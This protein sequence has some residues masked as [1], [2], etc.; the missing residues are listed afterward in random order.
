MTRHR[1]PPTQPPAHPAAVLRA[2]AAILLAL[3]FIGDRAGGRAAHAQ[4]SFTRSD[5]IEVL[6]VIPPP[7]DATNGDVWADGRLVVV[8]QRSG[9][10][11]LFDASVPHRT[12][13]VAAVRGETFTQD[14]KIR[15]DLVAVTNETAGVGAGAV[16]FGVTNP[17][18]PRELS[19]ITSP[20]ARSVH[21]L[22]I[23]DGFLYLS[24]NNTGRVEIFDI[25]I[26]AAPLHVASVADPNGRIHDAVV[27]GGRLYSSFLGGGFTVH[28]VSDPSRPA[29]LVS[30]DYPEAFTH[31]AWPSPDGRFLYTTDEVQGGH[32][33]VWDLG[34]AGGGSG[35]VHQVGRFIASEPAIIHNVHASGD[36]VFAAYYTA[37]LRILD[38]STPRLPV[39]VAFLDTFPGG[40][41][42]FDGAWGVHPFNEL[43]IAYISDMATGLWVVRFD[44]RVAAAPEDLQ[45]RAD[46]ERTALFAR[47]VVELRW[48]RHRDSVGYNIYRAETGAP[49]SRLNRTPH[50]DTTFLDVLPPDRQDAEYAVSA[51]LPDGTES[52]PSPIVAIRT[53]P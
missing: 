2:L 4:P 16:L 49:F 5:N 24:S 32:M 22:W 11:A 48:R 25:R 1:C 28:D 37:G 19:R 50:P 18:A 33:R 31:N 46:V 47:S 51:V 52:R 35:P 40:G 43:G 42:V 29:L 15:G 36:L 21:N 17:S 45:A 44:G 23:D 53:R 6:S 39:E 26:P 27:V 9:G 20:V 3:L 12:Q 14:V 34:D 30:H 8:A 41:Q 7:P 10:W 38:V 13:E